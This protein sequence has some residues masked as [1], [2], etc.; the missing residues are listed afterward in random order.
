MTKLE[1]L[2][3]ELCPDGV[4]YKKLGDG[5]VMLQP[6][7]SGAFNLD[8]NHLVGKM[9]NLFL[10]YCRL[11]YRKQKGYAVRTLFIWARY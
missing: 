2:T 6:A 3:K 4:E 10:R 11:C 5:W 9:M 8:M 7:Y 1:Q